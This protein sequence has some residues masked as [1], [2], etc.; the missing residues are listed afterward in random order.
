MENTCFNRTATR[1]LRSY[2]TATCTVETGYSVNTELDLDLWW[3]AYSVLFIQCD[4]EFRPKPKELILKTAISAER[5]KG[6]KE[7]FRPKGSISAETVSFGT[8]FRPK[9]TTRRW[10]FRPKYPLSA[11]ITLSVPFGFR[12]KCFGKIFVSKFRPKPKFCPFRSITSLLYIYYSVVCR[13]GSDI[14]WFPLGHM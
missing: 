2:H 14:G 7:Q 8:L 1:C 11:E 4:Q 6:P 10:I 12:P 13:V 3:W 5:R 9:L